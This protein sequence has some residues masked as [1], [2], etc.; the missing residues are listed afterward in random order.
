MS[1]EYRLLRLA[2]C[3]LLY[4]THTK[5]N[6]MLLNCQLNVGIG[7]KNSS[8]AYICRV[9]FH[10]TVVQPNIPFLFSLNYQQD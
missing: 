10:I 8:F 2:G 3:F 4:S 7:I 1:F 5:F 6:N 9:S